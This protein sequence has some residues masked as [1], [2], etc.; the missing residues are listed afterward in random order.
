MHIHKSV[1]TPPVPLPSPA[2]FPLSRERYQMEAPSIKQSIISLSVCLPCLAST[3]DFRVRAWMGFVDASKTLFDTYTRKVYV[4]TSTIAEIRDFNRIWFSLLKPIHTCPRPRMYSFRF[5]D[6]GFPFVSVYGICEL[7]MDLF[8]CLPIYAIP[9]P[10]MRASFVYLSIYICIHFQEK[11]TG[12]ER[13]SELAHTHR[14][15]DRDMH[16]AS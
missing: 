2:F 1:S 6:R 5:R 11:Q 13:G 16:A 15:S 10:T 12:Q 7:S 8:V 14:E 4:T 3:L 9:C